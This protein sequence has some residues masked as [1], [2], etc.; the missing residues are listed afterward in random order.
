MITG[1]RLTGG[2]SEADFMRRF[3]RS[4]WD[5][6]PDAREELA[7]F[8]EN[9]DVSIKKD[10]LAISEKGFDISNQILECFV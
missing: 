2:V 1:L 10:R 3:G 9:G 4:I 8:I 6:F 7:D 5:V